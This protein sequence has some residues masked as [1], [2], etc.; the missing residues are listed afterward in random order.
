MAERTIKCGSAGKIFSLTGWKV[1]WLIASP[2]LASIAARAHQ[3]LTFATP[4]NLQAAVAYG[5]NEGDSWLQPMRE[6]FT[7]ARNRMEQGL[8]AVG[9]EVLPSASTYF[10]CIDL[11]A[12]GIRLDDETFARLAVEQAGAAVIPLS[13]FSEQEPVTHMIRLCFAKRDETIDAGITAL[14]RAKELAR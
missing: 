4:P 7:R 13:A 2:E 1:G 11:A 3:F 14:A 10:Q 8:S 6:R 5:L 9:Y 12:S